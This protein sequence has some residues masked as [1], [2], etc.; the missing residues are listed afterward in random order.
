MKTTVNCKSTGNVE[1]NSQSPVLHSSGLTQEY[2]RKP[3]SQYKIKSHRKCVL[4]SRCVIMIGSSFVSGGSQIGF[5]KHGQ[6]LNI[7]ERLL[8]SNCIILTK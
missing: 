6:L 2:Y 5:L 4:E 3:Q 8:D 7:Y 1:G